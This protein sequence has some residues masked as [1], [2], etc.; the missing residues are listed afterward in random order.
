MQTSGAS[1]REVVKL[2]LE[3]GCRHCERSEAIHSFRRRHGLLRCARNDGSSRIVFRCLKIESGIRV[4]CT[5]KRAPPNAPV[6]PGLD[7]GIHQSSRKVLRRRWITRS[8]PVMTISIGI[9]VIATSKPTLRHSGARIRARTRNDGFG[10]TRC[11]KMNRRRWLKIESG[12][13]KGGAA[14][15]LPW[16]PKG[17]GTATQR[18][19]LKIES[20][21]A[22]ATRPVVS[23]G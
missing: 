2:R 6:M 11:L 18:C 4:R 9:K 17:E 8:S 12:I 15:P 22:V 5:S 1:R 10:F 3:S 19:G 7:P 13:C 23:T 14:L 16:G 20:I 21:V